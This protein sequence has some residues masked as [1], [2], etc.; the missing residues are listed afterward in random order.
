MI[1]GPGLP[2]LLEVV[3]F[4]TLKDFSVESRIKYSQRLVEK[5]GIPHLLQWQDT[6]LRATYTRVDMCMQSS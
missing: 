1:G 3:E 4:K 6:L 2:M 5:F